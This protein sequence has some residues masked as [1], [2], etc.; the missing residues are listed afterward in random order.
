MQKC[1]K[2]GIQGGLS[3]STSFKDW[4][5]FKGELW[6]STNSRS[7]VLSIDFTRYAE[8]MGLRVKLYGRSNGGIERMSRPWLGVRGVF[9]RLPT[10]PFD[11][12]KSHIIY[13][14]YTFFS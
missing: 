10:M 13:T 2:D 9:T 4:L 11:L 5:T 1:K 6:M 8:E 3:A 7:H 14:S 12:G